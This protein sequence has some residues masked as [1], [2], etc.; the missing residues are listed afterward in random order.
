MIK[1]ILFN[2]LYLIC[3]IQIILG[4]LWIVMHL[5]K[6]QKY[7]ENYAF[8]GN[9]YSTVLIQVII[10]GV[11]SV[12]F[13]QSYVSKGKAVFAGM[14]FVTVPMITQTAFVASRTALLLSAVLF[15]VPFFTQ[16][17][18]IKKRFFCSCFLL[19]GIILVFTAVRIYPAQNNKSSNS[20]SFYM[21][22]RFVGD[23]LG[24]YY[25]VW[26]DS[27]K[28]VVSEGEAI[29]IADSQ[30]FFKKDFTDLMEDAYGVDEAKVVYAEL[31]KKAFTINSKENIQL[32]A[33]D[34]IG[35][36]FMPYST[37]LNLYGQDRQMTGWNYS[38]FTEG[39]PKLSAFLFKISAVALTI[40]T[41]VFIATEIIRIKNK[42][43]LKQKANRNWI[44]SIVILVVLFGLSI[45]LSLV[46]AYQVDYKKGSF[47]IAIWYN[48][49]I[50]SIIKQEDNEKYEKRKIN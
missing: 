2:I 39:T 33:D 24:A 25:T 1:K 9:I 15:I 50:A 8:Q 49:M 30:T 45:Y 13:F 34:F 22:E 11:S 44:V 17:K 21:A 48:V 27:V 3:G 46:T 20:I 38:R 10:L 5:T 41:I 32:W 43:T 42:H 36:L 35:S 6:M 40:L 18:N 12:Y 14:F 23:D 16:R 7:S 28:T 47:I 31:A 4:S 26:P 19:V 29:N 37:Y